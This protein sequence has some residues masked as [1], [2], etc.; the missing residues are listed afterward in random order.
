MNSE[1]FLKFS[2]VSNGKK[3]HI[4]IRLW[5]NTLRDYSMQKYIK[6]YNIYF[7]LIHKHYIYCLYNES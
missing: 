6:I 7:L 5:V 2:L 4:N 1:K 3:F